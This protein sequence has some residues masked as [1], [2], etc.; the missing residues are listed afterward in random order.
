MTARAALS[1]GRKWRRNAVYT[2][3]AAS[4][5]KSSMEELLEQ[6]NVEAEDQRS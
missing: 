5:V 2:F 3:L 4:F 1:D 6:I